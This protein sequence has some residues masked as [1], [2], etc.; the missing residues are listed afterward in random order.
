MQDA[1]GTRERAPRPPAPPS[2]GAPRSPEDLP[3][4]SRTELRARWFW[5]VLIPNRPP[6]PNPN[7]S[8][9]PAPRL[10]CLQSLALCWAG[11]TPAARSSPARSPSPLG[12]ASPAPSCFSQ[13]SSLSALPCPLLLLLALLSLSPPLPPP[14]SLSLPL[15]PRPNR[16]P[17]FP[18][19]DARGGARGRASGALPLD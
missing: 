3:G 6:T 17:P 2:L 8:S 15:P 12:C 1:E 16:H 11:R 5:S 9:P 4:A 19:S 14:P 18:L 7:P 10:L 13:P